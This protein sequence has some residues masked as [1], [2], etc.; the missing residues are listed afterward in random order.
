MLVPGSIQAALGVSGKSGP[1]AKYNSRAETEVFML[2]IKSLVSG[3]RWSDQCRRALGTES[4]G[5]VQAWKC[6]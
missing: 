1:S 2:V 4:S 6:F 5:S 3:I